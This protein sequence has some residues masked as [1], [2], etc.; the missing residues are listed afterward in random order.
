[1]TER[2]ADE[3]CPPADCAC[4]HWLRVRRP[5]DVTGLEP[6]ELQARVVDEADGGDQTRSSTAAM[7]WPWPMHIV[8]IP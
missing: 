3:H 7:A 1:V 4:D 2:F 5:L 8:A 6:H